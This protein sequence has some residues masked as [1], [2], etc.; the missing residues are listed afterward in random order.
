MTLATHSRH[1]FQTVRF[2]DVLIATLRIDLATCAERMQRFCRHAFKYTNGYI[3]N[4]TENRLA[5]SQ[6]VLTEASTVSL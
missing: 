3:G 5:E 4:G 6:L 2:K 1:L